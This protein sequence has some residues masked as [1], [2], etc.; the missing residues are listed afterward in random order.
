MSEMKNS[1]DAELGAHPVSRSRSFM[2][3]L[4]FP[5]DVN[6]RGTLFG[7]ILM[8]YIDKIAGIAATRHC[9]KTVVTASTDSLEFLSP[10]YV[11]ELLV[12]EAFVTWTHRSSME[13]YCH[14]KA[15]NLLTGESRDTVTAFLTF[16]AVNKEGRPIPV[17]QVYPETEEEK[18]LHESAPARYAERMKR[19]QIRYRGSDP[20][21]TDN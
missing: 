20:A 21:S 16:V 12:L 8:Q 1:P 18:K 11:G 5:S 4:V 7:G 2:S 3:E 15:E 10:V 13:V 14:V 19:R 9:N 6:P 17:P